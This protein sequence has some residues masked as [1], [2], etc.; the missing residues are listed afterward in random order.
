[1]IGNTEI[2]GFLS[3]P[4]L[5]LVVYL[6]RPFCSHYISGINMSMNDPGRLFWENLPI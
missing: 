5:D 6:N 1:M 3:F 2:I 4:S